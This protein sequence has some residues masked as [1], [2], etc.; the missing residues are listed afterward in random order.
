VHI[1]DGV[2]AD[3]GFTFIP[4]GEGELPLIWL[5]QQLAERDYRGMVC[6][7]FEGAGDFVEGTRRSMAFLKRVLPAI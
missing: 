4:A 2:W 7:E 1:K 3:V 6:S 5:L